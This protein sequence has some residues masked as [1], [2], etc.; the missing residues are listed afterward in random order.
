DWTAS[1]ISH[2]GQLLKK[3]TKPDGLGR[4]FKVDITPKRLVLTM[5]SSEEAWQAIK[6]FV[7]E[8]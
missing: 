7:I 5:T 3:H 2:L 8:V 6:I 1:H 4:S